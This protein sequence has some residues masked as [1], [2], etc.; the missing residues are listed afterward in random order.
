MKVHL[1][2]EARD[3]DAGAEPPAGCEALVQDLELATLV[4]AM[5][6]GN[7]F[8]AE[9]SGKVL[10]ASLQDPDA[11]RYR[12]QVLA[13]CLAAPEVIREMYAIAAA[14]LLD[15]RNFWGTY[16]ASYQSPSSNLS[17]AVSYLGAY[18][19]RLRQLRA[20][21]DAHAGK[22][23]STGLRTLFATLHRELDDEYF[24]EISH[25][26]RQLR[27]R[28]GVLISAEL[29]RDN[30]GINFVLRDPCDAR[31]PW[32]E[33]LGIAPRSSY[34]FTLPPRDLAGG[35]ILDDLTGRGINLVANAAAQSADHIGSYFTMLRAE[36]AFYVGCL[37]LAGKLAAKGVPTT[38]P[39]PA[40]AS[41][42][43]FSCTDLRDT[44]LELISG[45]PVTGN[46][47]HADG[48]PLVIITGA[49]SGGKS[50]F[51]RSVGLAQLMMQCGLFVTAGS[52]QASAANG[53][54]THFT[55]AEDPGMTS[56]RLVD[57]L[58]RMSAITGHIR[59]HCLILFNESFAG[60]NEREG[61]EIG[62][63]IVRALLEA[64]VKVFFVT[65]RFDFAERFH[66]QHAHPTLFL[67]A[68]RQPDGRRSYKL[69]VKDPLPTSYGEDLY[70]R[71]GGWLDED[72]T[73]TAAAAA[74]SDG[75]ADMN[76]QVRQASEISAAPPDAPR[77]E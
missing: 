11:I 18:V 16:G 9:I 26:L 33:R 56:G 75:Q 61:S 30:S 64:H 24:E 32:K 31:R 62:H 52:Y 36:L 20:I 57:E 46:D 37:N 5:A 13:D 65:H 51:L 25:H 66:R 21:A 69:A 27:F 34:S 72:Q 50:T 12:Q 70:H 42:L 55:R 29:D 45:G 28:T 22:F 3:F 49:N 17:G 71:L 53:I 40:P 68:E 54:F 10:L 67:R 15:K 39:E 4:Q 73:L 43:T 47:V 19:A 60:T 59:P 58:R 38:V 48:T 76:S 7:E 1:L 77:T 41:S 74:A 35:Q 44:C 63:Q 8:L 23:R 6:N 2:H 14:A